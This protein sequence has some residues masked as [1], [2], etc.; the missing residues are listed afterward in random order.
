MPAAR[1][2]YLDPLYRLA[3]ISVASPI[4]II[5]DSSGTQRLSREPLRPEA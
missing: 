1:A 3:E 4:D 5:G 2:A